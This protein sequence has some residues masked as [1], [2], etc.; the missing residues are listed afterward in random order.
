MKSERKIRSIESVYVWMYVKEC[1]F[2]RVCIFCEKIE[3]L[4]DLSEWS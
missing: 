4:M 1:E 3:W 2:K